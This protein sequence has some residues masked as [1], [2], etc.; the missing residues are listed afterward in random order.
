MPSLRVLL[1]RL[2]PKLLGTTQLSKS[3]GY[4]ANSSHVQ[5]GGNI[6]VNRKGKS[7]IS[8]QNQSQQDMNSDGITYSQTYTVQWGDHRSEHNDTKS[9]Q[10][11]DLD[12]EALKSS[13]RVTEN[14]L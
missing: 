7:L 2:F 1:V 4:Y 3:N 9:I 8:S 13:G 11:S 5:T 14:E 6:S 12:T 10:M